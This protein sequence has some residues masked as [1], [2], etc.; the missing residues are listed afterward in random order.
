LSPRWSGQHRDRDAQ[1]EARGDTSGAPRESPASGLLRFELWPHAHDAAKDEDDRAEPDPTHEW[2]HVSLDRSDAGLRIHAAEHEI[3]VVA[4]R[5]HH[6][7]LGRRRLGHL[8]VDE[9]RRRNDAEDLAAARHLDVGEDHPLR[10]VDLAAFAEVLLRKTELRADLESFLADYTDQNP[11][12]VDTRFE[13]AALDKAVDRLFS[14]KPTEL[15][16]LTLA[17]GKLLVRKAGLET[18]LSRI[19]RAYS[20]DHPE[21]KRLKRKVEIYDSATNEILGPK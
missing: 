5:V 2:V 11:R 4:E 16:K 21:V 15:S 1:R 8:L 14:V 19:E 7:H 10:R 6:R 17:L 9:L 12:V 20:S 13:L 3:Q 18:D